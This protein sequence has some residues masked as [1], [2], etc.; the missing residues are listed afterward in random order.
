MKRNL[1]EL[2]NQ[3]FDVLIIGGGIHGAATARETAR[4]GLKTAL[5]EQKDFSHATSA[6]SQKIMHGGLRY[7]QHL[8]FKRMRESIKSRREMILIAPHLVKPL[9]CV[10]PTYGHGL[11]G[12]EVM[13]IALFLNDMISWDR[14]HAT[15]LDNYLPTGKI[16]SKENC[17]KILPN[18]KKDGLNGAAFWYDALAHNTERLALSFI[19]EAAEYGACAA[20][21]V[22]ATELV[23]KNDRIIGVKAKDSTTNDVFEVQASIVVNATGPW[24]EKILRPF[25][26]RNE[27]PQVWAKAVNI[28]V[29]KSLFGD[30][31]VG[32]EGSKSHIDKDT[33]FKKGKRFYFF[34]PWR[35]YTVIGTSYKPYNGN[36]GRFRIEINDIDELID[37]ANTIYPPADLTSEHVTF[38]HAGILPIAE[39]PG[40]DKFDVQWENRSLVI[41]HEKR[42]GIRGL[43]SI[44]GVKY[45]DAPQTAKEVM[46]RIGNSGNINI[47]NKI[48]YHQPSIS[49]EMT[50][51]ANSLQDG[52]N[53]VEKWAIEQHLKLSYG[54]HSG[55]LLQYINKD[56]KLA[57]LI[58]GDLP[59]TVAEIIYSIREEMALKLSDIVFRRT[60]LGT[61]ECP[62]KVIIKHVADIMANEL[63][64]D[65][66][67]KSEE[68]RE[69][70]I[71]YSPLKVAENF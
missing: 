62:P 63:G 53:G 39:W 29:K 47:K 46:K 66:N 4:A 17:L 2:I 64:W 36:P 43:I 26:I 6:N 35:G 48:P 56:K 54:R 70:L 57:T 37:E 10:I 18:I 8:N 15:G 24:L 20:N 49:D 16:L 14:N 3:H 52:L 1:S 40:E 50:L 5:I 59:L 45:T 68:I 34:V 65:E 30:H 25:G 44:K 60:D 21:Y 22:E 55:R 23:V 9:G 31:A 67:R 13:C 38:F 41:D 33:I 11:K 58:S 32:L 27:R 12:K 42:N 19:I 51:L 61:A 69:V 7:L 71:H 28:I